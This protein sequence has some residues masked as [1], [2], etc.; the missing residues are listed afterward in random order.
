[1]ELTI[2][3]TKSRYRL[4]LYLII[5]GVISLGFKLYFVDFS[6]PPPMDTYG[7][8]FHGFAINDGDFSQ[9]PRKTLGWSYFI[10]PF[11]LL[12]DSN[13]FLDYINI[14]KSVGIGVSLISIYPMYLLS[15][16]FFNEKY[17]LVTASLF[18]FEPHLNHNAVQGLS[19]PLYIVLTILAFLFILNKDSNKIYLSFL[20]AGLVWWVRWPGII[21]F[22]AIS[23]IYL[24]N[25]RKN[26]PNLAKYG[27]CLMVFLIVVSPML[28]QRYDQFGDPLYFSLT[29]NLFTGNFGTFLSENSDSIQYSAFDY[30]SDNGFLNFLHR[31]FVQGT[32]NLFD[33][34]I[35]ISFPYLFILIPFGMFFSFR[36]F[37]QKSTFF[38]SNWIILI[39]SLIGL[40]I[41]FSVVPDR[42]FLFNVYPFLILFS[43]LPIQ[44]VT[45]YGLSTFSFSP[46]QKNLFLVIVLIIVIILSSLFLLRYDNHDEIYENEKRIFAQTMIKNFDG[47]ILISDEDWR[48]FTLL[49]FTSTSMDFK[50]YKINYDG[51]SENFHILT[52]ITIHGNTIEEIINNGQQHG[53]SLIAVNE[54]DNSAWYQLL[55]DVYQNE[56][57]YP[58]LTKIFDSNEMNFKEFKVKVFKI[59]YQNFSSNTMNSSLEK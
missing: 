45:E 49:K 52:P 29:T 28:L 36:A 16:K 13:N 47:R 51:T 43:I 39:I 18:A 40:I 35:R 30:V 53:L 58:Y 26:P 33:Q 24:L 54:S 42:R 7:Y 22:I 4:F 1:M 3:T 56:K 14:V 19:E 31:F 9:P 55:N 20:F 8:L 41:T 59:D 17:S 27:I 23:I 2:I 37:D 10:S 44:R 34:L 32:Y 21:I 25:S 57:N 50:S 38:R 6:S 15:R 12:S 5:I 11:L 46:K 48:Y